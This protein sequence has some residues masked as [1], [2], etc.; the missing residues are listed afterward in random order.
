MPAPEQP[1]VVTETPLPDPR[2]AVPP[3]SPLPQP[4]LSPLQVEVPLQSR[5][6]PL[7]ERPEPLPSVATPRLNAQQATTPLL[8]ASAPELSAREIPMPGRCRR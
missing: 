7:A 8:R 6:V 2:F 1:L 4:S 5:D 3:A